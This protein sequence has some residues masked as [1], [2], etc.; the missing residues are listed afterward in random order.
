MELKNKD[1]E[2]FSYEEDGSKVIRVNSI[3]AEVAR[4]NTDLTLKAD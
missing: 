3:K 4:T 2:K 1:T